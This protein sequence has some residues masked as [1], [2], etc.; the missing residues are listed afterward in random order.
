MEK[1]SIHKHL[2]Y[3]SKHPS[4]GLKELYWSVGLM[5]LGVAAVTIFEPIFLF[6]LG[7]S[8]K[9]IMF[10]YLLVYLVY[11]LI[12]PLFGKVVAHFGYEHSILYSQFF[13]I[14]FYVSLFA[15][16]SIPVF[17]YI[18][19]LFLAIQKALYWPSYHADFTIF[20]NDEQRGRELSGIETLSMIVYVIGPLAG[21]FIL[22]WSNFSTLF[23]IA[24]ALFLLSAIPLLRI[25][26]IHSKQ[27]FQY[28]DVFKHLID[29][30]HRRNFIAFL[31]FGEELIVLTVWPI[32]I[33]TLIQNYASIGEIVAGATLITGGVVLLIGKIS[34]KY[35]QM[36]LL[37]LG[38]AIYFISWIFRAFAS[39]GWHILSLDT[40]SRF[41]KEMV[42]LPI[43][44]MTYSAAKKLGPLSHGIFY[45]QS[46]AIAKV[47]AASLAIIVIYYFVDP[48][49][50]IFCLAAGF[51]L[52]YLFYKKSNP[53]NGPN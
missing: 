45:E 49:M 39:K 23:I 32:F 30:D 48:W 20:S 26:E 17:F 41:S 21:G 33:Y 6:T 27:K 51:S 3:F 4:R 10:F 46:T 2:H 53:K 50:P 35:G 40:T 36:K 47:F 22:V 12:L 9:E 31:G 37:R 44:S 52:L 38:S 25:K 8:L 43:E 1:K 18:A 28:K 34:D 29:K 19:P 5:D 7:Y 24:S 13:L 16:S 11:T 42:F 14:A 15:I